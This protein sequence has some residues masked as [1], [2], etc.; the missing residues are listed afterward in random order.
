MTSDSKDQHRWRLTPDVTL[1]LTRIR[2]RLESAEMQEHGSA[3]RLPNVRLIQLSFIA[4]RAVPIP[5]DTAP[6]DLWR[7]Q[8]IRRIIEE[9]QREADASNERGM[10][11]TPGS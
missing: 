3:V 9:M 11:A 6:L 2:I 8:R 1:A 4:Y 7:I 5:P 10:D